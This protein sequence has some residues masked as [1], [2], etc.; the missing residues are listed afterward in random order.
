MDVLELIDE[1]HDLVHSAKPV[2]LR[3]QLRVDKAKLYDMLDRT[4]STIPEELKQARRI[5]NER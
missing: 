4:R 5:V 3:H 1:L 2:P